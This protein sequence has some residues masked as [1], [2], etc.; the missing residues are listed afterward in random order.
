MRLLVIGASGGVG[1][2]LVRLA[3][4]EGHGVTA[5]VRDATAIDA[6]ARILIDDV[7]QPGCFDKH[8]PG[9]DAVLS[10]LGIKRIRP[11]NPWSALASPPDMLSKAAAM[12]VRAMW[13]AGMRRVIAVSAA[14][15]ADSAARMNVLMKAFVA[16]S[17]VGVAYRDLAAMEGVFAEARLD[18]C[19]PRPTRLTDGPLTRRVRQADSFPMT[20]AISRADVAWWMLEQVAHEVR[21][22][23]PT[24]TGG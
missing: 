1:K 14:G 16:T 24:I 10:A 2:H 17:N 19:C 21:E 3:C 11:A 9:H 7:K 15:V 23:T 5:I 12:L 6:R 18:W 22:R 4:D 20:A 8:L 13:H